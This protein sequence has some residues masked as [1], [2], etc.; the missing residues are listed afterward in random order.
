MPIEGLAVLPR[1]VKSYRLVL[2]KGKRR[3]AEYPP[4][5]TEVHA[6]VDLDH[7]N[8]LVLSKS[9]LAKPFTHAIVETV[10]NRH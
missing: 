9:K 4:R 6:L 8:S 1:I 3:V 2:F 7:H 10:Y 5:P